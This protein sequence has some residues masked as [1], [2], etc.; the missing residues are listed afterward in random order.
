MEARSRAQRAK[1]R[2]AARTSYGSNADPAR[3][4]DGSPTEGSGL[5]KRTKS[6]AAGARTASRHSSLPYAK[7]SADTVRP[8]RSK[9]AAEPIASHHVARYASSAA[10][11]GKRSSDQRK[12]LPAEYDA[13]K[14]RGQLS[15]VTAVVCLI[16]HDGVVRPDAWLALLRDHPRVSLVIHSNRVLPAA[17]KAYRYPHAAVSAWE[18]ISL[19]NLMLGMVGYALATYPAAGY[20]Y[21]CPGN[22]IPIVGAEEAMED[23]RRLQ[24]NLPLGGSLLG[25]P[26]WEEPRT[27]PKWEPARVEAMATQGLPPIPA[28]CYGSMFVGLSRKHAQRLVELAPKYLP[29]LTKAYRAAYAHAGTE[30]SAD[31]ARLHPEE[32]FIPYL[33]HVVDSRAWPTAHFHIMA[34]EQDSEPKCRQCEYRAGHGKLLIGRDEEAR[35]MKNRRECLFLRKVQPLG[36]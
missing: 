3:P 13:R 28:R 35:L 11:A 23:P 14:R 19:L 36:E 4:T 2:A 10:L 26:G 31:H 29:L 12:L 1:T 21:T 34:E 33:L 27:M 32:E 30:H 5:P 22:G 17:L 25:I 15:D 16:A 8:K 24:P 18:D 6:V 7:L 9:L 20:I